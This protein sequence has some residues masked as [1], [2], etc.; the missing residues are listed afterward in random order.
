MFAVNVAGR[1]VV[2][3]GVDERGRLLDTVEAFDADSQTWTSLPPIPAL[4]YWRSNLI[5]A[6]HGNKMFLLNQMTPFQFHV[7]DFDTR[8][9]S[10]IDIPDQ[11]VYKGWPDISVM[12]DYIRINTH[13]EGKE[14]FRYNV[15]TGSWATFC[16]NVSRHTAYGD[17]I[18]SIK[19]DGPYRDRLLMGYVV[20]FSDDRG[21][22]TF[23]GGGVYNCQLN[24]GGVLVEYTRRQTD[25]PADNQKL[26]MKPAYRHQIPVRY[27]LIDR[28][29]MLRML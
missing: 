1:L 11:V 6:A 23:D 17:R 18:M 7:F 4:I 29:F 22:G 26:R 27:N 14:M 15:L 20:S 5:A 28:V 24:S 3:G 9:W 19:Y 8:S 12:G 10:T 2:G 25:N 16:S 13:N 21:T